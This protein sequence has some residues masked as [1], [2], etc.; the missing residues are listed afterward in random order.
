MKS[1]GNNCRKLLLAATLAGIATWAEVS[2]AQPAGDSETTNRIRIVALEGTVEVS[3]RGAI[4]WVTTV[5]NQI[6][7]PFDRVRTGPNSRMTLR[8]SDESVITIGARTELE[9]LSPHEPKDEFGLHLIKGILSFFHRD[10]PGRIRVITSGAQAG[11][12]GTEFVLAVDTNGPVDRTTISVIDGIVQFYND[13]GSRTLTNLQQAV[14]E[15]GQPPSL[16]VGFVANNV[17]Q[18]CF[19]YPA[20]LDLREVPLTSQEEA[21][22]SDSLR[23]YRAGDLVAALHSY[24]AGRQAASAAERLY[25][26]AVLLSVGQVEQTE[27]T[28]GALSSATSDDR[29]QRLASALRRLVAAVKRQDEPSTRTPQLST[30]LMA[31]SYYEQSRAIRETSLRTALDLAHRAATNSPEFGFAWE[32]VAEL[33]FSF[34]RTDRALEALNRSLQLSPRN[35]QALALKGFLLAAQNRESEA[36]WWFEDALAVDPTL[37]NAWLGRGLCRIRRGNLIQGRED[38]LV[39]AALEPQRALL[40]NYLGKAYAEKGDFPRASKELE[41]AKR[42]DKNDPTAWLYSALLNQQYNRV[43]EAIRDLEHSQEL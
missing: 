40:R 37:A 3:P 24:P 39:A 22:L 21:A 4:T 17:L 28:L 12:R 23:A 26:A 31:S 27:K 32:R 11:V 14:A 1:L 41:L 19:Y 33:E 13:Q 29:I 8:W 15:P 16:P 10:R 36:V 5:T 18:W 7:R 25:Y 30:E 20:V 35:A 2:L 43:N 42:L 6:L 34:G 9:I 38:L